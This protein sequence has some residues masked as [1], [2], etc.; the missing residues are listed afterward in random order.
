MTSKKLTL[1]KLIEILQRQPDKSVI[2]TTGFHNPHSYRGHY[3]EIAFELKSN[4]SINNM[5]IDAQSSIG[6]TMT[7][8]AGGEYTMGFDTIVNIA[9][10]GTWNDDTSLDELDEARLQGMLSAVKVFE[11][12]KEEDNI[13]T[14]NVDDGARIDF[15][16]PIE[17]SACVTFKSGDNVVFSISK[18]GKITSN[19]K[20]VIGDEQFKI[21]MM[22]LYFKLYN[23]ITFSANPLPSV[24]MFEK[25]KAFDYLEE[26]VK[27]GTLILGHKENGTVFLTNMQKNGN[28]CIYYYKNLLEIISN[29]IKK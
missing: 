19:G 27:S 13:N 2:L 24:E 14:I 29:K 10:Q 21:A 11:V 5:L 16:A 1:G 12:R 26:Q 4:V 15:D 22:D 3:E 23:F 7:G 25:A 6:K 9:D 8:Y 20:E 18:A 17:D 28:D